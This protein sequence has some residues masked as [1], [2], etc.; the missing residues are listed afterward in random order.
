MNARQRRFRPASSE[1]ALFRKPEAAA[2]PSS[3]GPGT[4]KRR[5]TQRQ[6]YRDFHPVTSTLVILGSGTA[7]FFTFFIFTHYVLRAFG[8]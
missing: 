8:V 1:L 2:P 3:T 5:A 6:G 7:A 4:R